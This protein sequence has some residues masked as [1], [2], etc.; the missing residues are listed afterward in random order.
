M[1]QGILLLTL[2]QIV[3]NRH[4][5]LRSIRSTT[6]LS[7][8]AFLLAMPD[9]AR[10]DDNILDAI[11]NADTSWVGTWAGSPSGTNNPNFASSAYNATNAFSNQTI[12]LIVHAS[13]GGSRVRIRLSNEISDAPI[14]IGSAHIALTSMGAGIIAGSDRTLT[15]NG[16]SLT[17]TI[18]PN[19]VMLSDFVK[20]DVPALAD[21]SVS[22][23]STGHGHCHHC[24]AD[25]PANE[26]RRADGQWRHHWLC[27][28]ITGHR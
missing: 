3:V 9:S 2:L 27:D 26:L 25:Q 24:R 15:F 14:N 18:P 23:L 16:G 1:V 7:V 11:P 21:L 19:A 4:W 22:L 12:R 20:L 13:L 10:C 5:L 6:L 28:P 17:V 8:G